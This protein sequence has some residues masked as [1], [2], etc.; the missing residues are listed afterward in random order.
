MVDD[1]Q[2]MLAMTKG[3]TGAGWCGG[4]DAH[5]PIGFT[6]VLQDERPDLALID[7][8]M[9]A[10]RGDQLAE[11]IRHRLPGSCPDGPVF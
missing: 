10:L 3:G 4:G 2:L 6:K 8:G 9:P 11:M 5:Q 7:V 1:G